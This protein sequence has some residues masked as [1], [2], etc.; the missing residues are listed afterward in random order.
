[1]ALE[2]T[3]TWLAGGGVVTGDLK[4]HH[5]LG[6]PEGTGRSQQLGD[7]LNRCEPFPTAQAMHLCAGEGLLT[8]TVSTGIQ[9]EG[10]RRDMCLRVPRAWVGR[11]GSELLIPALYTGWAPHPSLSGF[12]FL[13]DQN[14]GF[15][16]LT[17]QIQSPG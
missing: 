11:I 14:E 4:S 2:E 9:G 10:R 8:G 15:P 6:F 1:M 12:S 17:L 7:T 5:F 13:R 3:E 16:A